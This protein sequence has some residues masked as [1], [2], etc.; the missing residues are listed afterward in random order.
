MEKTTDH[1]DL[2]E[3]QLANA[4]E[5]LEAAREELKTLDVENARGALSRF[6]AC[7]VRL[8]GLGLKA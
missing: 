7:G 1:T 6:R 5:L 2:L 4:K 8:L 3:R